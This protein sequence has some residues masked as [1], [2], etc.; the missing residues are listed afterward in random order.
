MASNP[1]PQTKYTPQ[2]V[3]NNVYDDDNKALAIIGYGSNGVNTVAND[4][5]NLAIAVQTS[6]SDTYVGEA[7]PGTALATAK[8]KA[9]KVDVGGNLTFAD[10][11]SS[12][13]NVATDLT[14]LTYS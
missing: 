14:A 2:N 9:Y 11:N 8:W 7:A 3:L 12:Y 5:D 4:S 10:G 13:D 6:G 1:Q